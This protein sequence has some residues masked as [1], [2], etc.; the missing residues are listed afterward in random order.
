MKPPIPIARRSL[1]LALSLLFAGAWSAGAQGRPNI[2][3]VVVDDLRF[4]DFGAA[5]HPFSRTP[6]STAWLETAHVSRTC[7]R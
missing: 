2:V 5:G 4:D 1:L 3:L 7:S 6:T